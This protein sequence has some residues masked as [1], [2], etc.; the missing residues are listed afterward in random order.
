MQKKSL[1]TENSDELECAVA[2]IAAAMADLSRVKM[3]SALMDGRAWTATELS[4]AA[5]VAPS[6]ASGHLAR[7]VEGKLIVCLS[8]GRHRYYR[9]A[10]HDVAEL[11]EQ[12]M[13]ISWSRI[14]PPETT[15]PKSMREARTCYDHL[16]GTIAVQ[17]YDFM[18]TENWLEPDGS[19]LT[20]HGRAQFLKLG[21]PVNTHSRRKACC[22]CLDWSERRFHLGGEAGAA[23]LIFLETK[24][25]IQRVAGYREV[26]VT[27]SGKA[28]IGQHFSR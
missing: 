9:L 18:Q 3:L 23:L 10:G 28:A 14:M 15:A 27:P 5:D 6:T 4:A 2:A 20:V 26:V 22:A 24:G 7:L 16:A 21:I 8:Q 25:W 19:A 17:I 1:P 11:V 12:I 13:G